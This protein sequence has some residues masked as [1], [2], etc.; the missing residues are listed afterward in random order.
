MIKRRRTFKLTKSKALMDRTR[1]RVARKGTKKALVNRRIK[2][3]NTSFEA[4]HE[5]END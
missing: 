5:L 4:A 2:Q 1:R 3:I